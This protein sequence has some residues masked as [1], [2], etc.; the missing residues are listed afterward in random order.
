MKMRSILIKIFLLGFTLLGNNL[1][2]AGMNQNTGMLFGANHAFYFTA[3]NGWIL[4]KN[5][6]K[7]FGLF[8]FLGKKDGSHRLIKLDESKKEFLHLSIGIALMPPGKYKTA[9]AKG[10][11]DECKPDEPE[12]LELKNPGID[13]FIFESGNSVFFWEQNKN[14]FKRIWMSD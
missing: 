10:Y 9:C 2:Y 6:G 3:H 11:G 13:Y 7:E 8:V 5:S 14:A 4:I 12:V 1:V